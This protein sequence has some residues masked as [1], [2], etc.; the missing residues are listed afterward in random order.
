MVVPVPAAAAD[1]MVI[2][3]GVRE[4]KA[5]ICADR[6]DMRTGANRPDVCAS[7]GLLGRR[8]TG[9][10]QSARKG[11]CKKCF[12]VLPL[13]M[14]LGENARRDSLVSHSVAAFWRR[15]IVSQA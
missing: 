6:P 8:R 7:A 1:A 15:Q 13:R 10:E 11:C 12:H 4:T 14:P 9:N 2:V 3:R 5:D